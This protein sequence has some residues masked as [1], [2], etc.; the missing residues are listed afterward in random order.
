MDDTVFKMKSRSGIA[1]N[2]MSVVKH[3][4]KITIVKTFETAELGML[5]N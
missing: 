4:S 3:G 5:A 1:A 2:W